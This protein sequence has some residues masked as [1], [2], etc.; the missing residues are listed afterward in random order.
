MRWLLKVRVLSYVAVA[1]A[2]VLCWRVD[3]ENTRLAHLN[4]ALRASQSEIVASANSPVLIRGLTLSLLSQMDTVDQHLIKGAKPCTRQLILIYR[5]HCGACAQQLSSWEKL[6]ADSRLRDAETWLVSIG[7]GLAEARP[8]SETLRKRNLPYRVLKVKDPVAFVVRT[9]LRGVPVTIVTRSQ[10][11]D[12][13]VELVQ[14]GLAGEQR[15][16]LLLQ[17]F[18]EGSGARGA[19]ILPFGEVD[20]L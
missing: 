10:N 8:I 20:P 2:L 5:A 13:V 15:L 4:E 11:S 19:R 16:E 1:A 6:V 14:E 18:A 17:A 9:G 12:S 7:D 3:R